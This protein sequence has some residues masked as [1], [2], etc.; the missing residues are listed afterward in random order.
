MAENIQDSLH[1]LKVIANKSVV[2]QETF[3]IADG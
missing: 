3:N 1:T 2:S